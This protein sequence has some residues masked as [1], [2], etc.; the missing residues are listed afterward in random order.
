MERKKNK[1]GSI[2]KITFYALD[3]GAI[4]VSFHVLFYFLQHVYTIYPYIGLS[5]P[6][7]NNRKYCCSVCLNHK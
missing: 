4:K 1:V 3:Y 7:Q 2:F 6:L 5:I